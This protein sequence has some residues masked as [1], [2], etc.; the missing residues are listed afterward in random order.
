MSSSPDDNSQHFAVFKD[1][2]ARRI[3][4]CSAITDDHAEGG[5]EQLDDFTSFLADQTWPSLPSA[6]QTA[7]YSNRD[8]ISAN[9]NTDE[10]GS[11]L[12]SLALRSTSPAVID[13]LTTFGLADDS[14]AAMI[15]LRGVVVDYLEEV[16]APPPVWSRTRAGVDACEICERSEESIRLTYHHLIPRSVH[17]KALKRKWHEE[18]MLG[19][20]AWLCR[21]VSH[22]SVVL[23]R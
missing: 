2:L 23:R 19:S 11:D 5:T 22:I 6:L 1:V 21:C 8:S 10:T 7:S 12:I 16:C 17:A 13:T 18:H 9:T 4:S 20:V 14:D 15:L 3:L